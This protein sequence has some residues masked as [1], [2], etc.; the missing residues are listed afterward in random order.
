M[1]NTHEPLEVYVGFDSKVPHVT[2][3]CAFSLSR[4]ATIPLSVLALNQSV[5]RECGLYWRD[6]DP[7]AST[8][9]TYS[10][11]LVP[12]LNGYRS[13][14]VYCDND[15]LWLSD[16]AD[17]IAGLDQSAGVSCV[18]HHHEPTE[19]RKMDGQVQTRYPRKNWSSLMLF[20]CVDEFVRKL[21]V[22]VANTETGKF[23]HRFEWIPDDRIGSLTT[24]WNWLE[25][26][27][28]RPSRGLPHVVHFTRG[29][30][31]LED[32]AD[33]DYADLW[34]TEHAAWEAAGKPRVGAAT[35]AGKS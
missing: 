16:I 12:A 1:V 23:L 14:A 10:R 18:Q 33:V 4:R 15:F 35:E 28:D 9:F 31:W 19:A 32:W 13:R 34:R 22:E 29:G 5:L 26:H 27:N 8:E 30:P 21:T 24:E 25:G 17:L 11:F 7:L 2:D 3:I 6:G 20:D